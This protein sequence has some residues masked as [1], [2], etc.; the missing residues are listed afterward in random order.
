MRAVTACAVGVI[1]CLGTVALAQESG[2][3]AP[4]GAVVSEPPADVEDQVIVRGRTRKMLRTELWRAEEAFYDRFNEL[5]SNDEF[6]IH[7]R[8]DASGPRVAPRVCAANFW[9]KVQGKLAETA[10]GQQRGMGPGTPHVFIEQGMEKGRLAAAEM[11]QLAAEDAELRSAFLYMSNLRDAA[12]GG[13]VPQW[14]S[15]TISTQATRDDQAL[16]YDAAVA[17]DVRV[18][19]EAWSHMLT[20]RTFTLA[21]V[22]GD[23]RGME[24]TCGRQSERLDY[25]PG[26]EWTLPDVSGPCTLLVKASFGTTFSLFEF[27]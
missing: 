23:I 9:V 1:A 19:R 7:C 14:W 8:R 17:A 27:D 6:D 10:L 15:R 5:N 18:A 25:E 13:K 20:Q 12:N 26:R 4:A 22:F 2:P 24:M 21:H 3:A 11:R 16:P